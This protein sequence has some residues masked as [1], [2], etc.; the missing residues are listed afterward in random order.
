VRLS[1]EF[2]GEKVERWG[3]WGLGDSGPTRPMMAK[4]LKDTAAFGRRWGKWG[5][6]ARESY[7]GESTIFLL[8]CPS[9]KDLLYF[10]SWNNRDSRPHLPQNLYF[11]GFQRS[12]TQNR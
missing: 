1:R 4:N 5:L 10:F 3:K 8:W 12:I 6:R 7:G 2:T 9:I 11:C